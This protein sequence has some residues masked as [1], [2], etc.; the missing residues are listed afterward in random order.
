MFLKKKNP[1][2]LDIG[3]SY[4][5]I[6]QLND[7]KAGYE[8]ASAGMLPLRPEIIVD[9]AIADKDGLTNALKDL[10]KKAGIKSADAVIG[11]SGHSSVIIKKITIPVMTEDELATSIKYEAEQYIPFDINEVNLDFQILGPKPEEGQMDVVLVAVKKNTIQEY[12]EAIEAAGLYPVIVDVDSFALVNM[13]EAN[14]DIVEGKN[15][16]LV[17]VGASKTN[18]DILREGLPIFTRDSAIG[19]NHHTEALERSLEISREDAERLKQG[20]AIEGVS[21]IDVQAA[22]TS[23]SEEIY[24]EIYRSFEYYRS[25][26]GDDEISEIILSGGTT[27]VNG[28]ASTMAERLGIQVEIA[29]PFKKIR[30]PEKLDPSFIKDSAPMLAV[31]VGLAMRRVGDR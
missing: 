4:L 2:G 16:A 28:F 21:A 7:A 6:V 3:S 29:D 18:I 10:M 25:S 14:Y 26:V 23:A 13:Y 19:G 31:A 9:G 5:K 20:Q 11:V 15:I 27:R 30:V 8:V 22:L 12:V 17:N 24:N 1:V